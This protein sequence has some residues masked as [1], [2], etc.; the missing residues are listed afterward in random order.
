MFYS[1]LI[2]IYMSKKISSERT[3]VFPEGRSML[4][5]NMNTPVCTEQKQ[6]RASQ[7]LTKNCGERNMNMVDVVSSAHQCAVT[8]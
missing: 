3:N 5:I 8:K 6:L 1:R 4:H 2:D 7:L